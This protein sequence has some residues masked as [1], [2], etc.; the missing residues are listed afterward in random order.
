[1]N[2]RNFIKNAALAAVAAPFGVQAWDRPEPEFD[3]S[4]DWYKKRLLDGAYDW[5]EFLHVKPFVQPYGDGAL[6]I[7][8]RTRYVAYSWALV[9]QDGGATW[10]RVWSQRDGIRDVNSCYHEAVVRGWNRATSLKY[11]IVARPI[12]MRSFW[13]N[14]KFFGEDLPNKALKGYFIDRKSWNALMKDRKEN[15]YKGEEFVEEG[16]LKAVDDENFS[17]VM[18]N[19]VHHSVKRYEQLIDSAPGDAA[20]A[21]LCGDICDH[22]RSEQDFDCFLS[23]PMSYLSRKLRCGVRFSRGNH[24][25]MGLYAPFVRNHVVMP[26]GR[27]YDAFSIGGTRIVNL[28]T[29]NVGEDDEFNVAQNYYGMA[30]YLA[31][32]R[33]WLDR[34][35]SSPEWKGA[36]RRL[37]FSH[38]PPDEKTRMKDL[39]APLKEA[40]VTLLA[41]GHEHNGRFCEP[42]EARPYPMVVGG[43][44]CDKPHQKPGIN[45]LTTLSTVCVRGGKVEV[46]Q[47]DLNGR[48]VFRKRI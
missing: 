38:I 27:F 4:E 29:G 43:G 46:S 14:A 15:G 10:T 32:E 42:T 33:E 18:F 3:P 31:E 9:S 39:Y 47:A 12:E 30:E 22:A 44:P 28:D 1:M 20:L 5:N 16:E 7:M 37:V 34:E 11:R 45:Q 48:E 8:W 24:E 2:R 36:K 23:G 25:T 41:C 26:N 40:G 35:V 17:I 13:G 6:S 21:V 19:D